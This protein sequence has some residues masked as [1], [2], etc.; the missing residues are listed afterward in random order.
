VAAAETLTQK[1][2]DDRSDT[3]R[4]DVL[5][6]LSAAVNIE[7]TR[8]TRSRSE[9]P[10]FGIETPRG[11]G[12]LGS[13]EAIV[14]NR[15]FRLKVAELTNLIPR[16]FK[17]EQWDPIAQGLLE[18]AE[19]ADLGV[20][21]TLAGRAET[22][23][24]LYL[25]NHSHPSVSDLSEKARA[26]MPIRLE[27]FVG[28]DG[29]TRIFASGFRVWL[30]EHQHEPMTGNQIAELLSA[31]GAVPETHHFKVDGRRTTR[32]LWKLARPGEESAP[33]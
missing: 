2:P 7:I 22:L 29:Y 16:S 9:P 23:V 26:V 13:V 4:V 28:A 14:S 20:E 1:A 21:T 30:A 33:G 31:I 11:G 8:V 19:V 6:R 10:V 17:A 12:S 5:K 3:E 24:S 32:S 15:K 18:V 27:P 25:G